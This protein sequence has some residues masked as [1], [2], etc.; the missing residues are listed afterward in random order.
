LIKDLA[1][2]LAE[3]ID[4]AATAR[5]RANV[6]S[7]QPSRRHAYIWWGT[8][9]AVAAALIWFL[10]IPRTP[11]APVPDSQLARATPPVPSVF[12][13]DRPRIPPADID[14]TVRG[15]SKDVSLENQ[16]GAALDKADTGDVGGAM[17]ALEAIAKRHGTSPIA[18]L[19]LGA[20]QLRADQNAEA[21]ATLDR[22]HGLK[23]GAEVADEVNWFLSIALV[24]TNHSD[25]ARPILE[26][27]CTHG[28]PRAASA[29]A[30][31]AEID[32]NKS[33]R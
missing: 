22:A 31:V 13:V 14:L 9:L 12:A 10:V 30:G 18:A 28:G 19:A 2:V 20:V 33:A 26:G 7:R 17:S 21:A 4:E 29:C 23:S 15:A 3:D 6:T 25:R 24:R 27:V 16:I 8:G 1:E 32:R 5:I 11:V